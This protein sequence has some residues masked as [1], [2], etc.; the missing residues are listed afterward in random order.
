[1]Q[2][3]GLLALTAVIASIGL[4]AENPKV[5]VPLYAI[6]FLAI[7]GGMLFFLSKHKRQSFESLKTPAYVPGIYCGILLVFSFTFPHI[8]IGNFRPDFIGVGT[9]YLFTLLLI[10][11]GFLGV[12]LIN[13]KAIKNK[14]FA[15]IGFAVLVI[16]AAI[17]A[18]A[19]STIDATYGTLGVIYFT[20]SVW[21][22]I[23]WSA[24]TLIHKHLILKDNG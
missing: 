12:W 22:A 8:S 4:A 14:V 15:V 10:C 18:L 1:M 24:F 3:L 13:T 2:A 11:L 21:A 19:A 16:T 5:M 17:P 7:I 20:F 6:I 23:V 9:I